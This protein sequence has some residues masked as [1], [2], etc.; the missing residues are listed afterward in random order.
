MADDDDAGTTDAE[1]ADQ[2]VTHGEIGKLIRDAL[3][4][5]FGDVGPVNDD[6]GD[7][8]ADSGDD[9]SGGGF[10]TFAEIEEVIAAQVQKAV[11]ALTGKK[12]PAA[13]K[14]GGVKKAA[15][16]EPE[17]PPEQPRRVDL[18]RRF[19]GLR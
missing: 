18:R 6:E 15:T 14:A 7:G 3:T 17:A 16:K 10:A 1:N 8:A 4:D 5:F 19:W 13:K 2:P 9:G 12:G 11:N